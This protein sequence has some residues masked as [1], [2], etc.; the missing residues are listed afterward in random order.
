[1]AVRG[2][3]A[4]ARHALA[5]AA[6]LALLLACAPA[7]AAAAR[8]PRRGLLAG[9]S[10]SR[11]L[12]SA[13]AAPAVDCP[14]GSGVPAGAGGACAPCK[15]GTWSVGGP[16]ARCKTCPK[17]YD[18]A[19][20]GSKSARAC[21]HCRA[22]YGGPSTCAPCPAGTW[23]AAKPGARI[24]VCRACPVLMTTPGPGAKSA[25]A[26]NQSLALPDDPVASALLRGLA[27][28]A[29]SAPLG[30]PDLASW[31]PGTDPCTWAGVTCSERAPRVVTSVGIDFTGPCTGR[32]PRAWGELGPGL[33][34]ISLSIASP[35]TSASD[36]SLPQEWRN[37]TGL[38]SLTLNNVGV[39]GPLSLAWLPPSMERL[40]LGGTRFTSLADDVEPGALPA[41][42][43]LSV[44]QD[45][46]YPIG[47]AL[48]GSWSNLA[49]LEEL[50]VQVCCQELSQGP[51]PAPGGPLPDRRG[52]ASL[53]QLDLTGLGLTGALSLAALPPAVQ[54]VQIA[55]GHFISLAD[56]VV[57]GDL[58]A[59]QSLSIGQYPQQ[60]LGGTLPASWSQLSALQE[61]S[62]QGQAL[63]GPLPEAW[64][65]MAALQGLGL[66]GNALSGELPAAWGSGMANL[67]WL[68]LSRNNITGP[69]PEAWV[70]M[71]TLRELRLSH[72]AL[73]GPL[74]A[75]LPAKLASLDLSH[76]QTE[77]MMLVSLNLT[78]NPLNASL[79]PEWGSM[80]LMTLD[81]SFCD[82][83]GEFPATPW[84][85]LGLWHLAISDNPQLS[86]CLPRAWL[87][88]DMGLLVHPREC[89][90]PDGCTTTWVLLRDLASGVALDPNPLRNTQ[91]TGVCAAE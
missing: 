43:K 64:A 68:D 52:M 7:G 37:L 47:G 11:S 27:E 61:L 73:S 55:L 28:L 24:R 72:N 53:K 6:A 75:K 40:D 77:S 80:G 32:L 26:C 44:A 67:T 66:G 84:A 71:A 20:E 59:L 81:L 15:R 89:E 19:S 22:G 65:S 62:I 48:P 2:S 33:E 60:R 46:A 41:L 10:G 78:G 1:M 25:A 3:R 88:R 18:T 21:S 49:A 16:D 63:T 8:G 5:L 85:A 38:K 87:E 30:N 4:L 90:L 31:R 12:T 14:A 91:L 13:R 50:R 39:T 57:S 23:R 86:G 42:R 35:C 54:M 83:R 36:P 56:D 76:N 79:P 58:P 74:P 82:L 51:L 9:E 69:I 45:S 17:G 29:G 70:G 34:R